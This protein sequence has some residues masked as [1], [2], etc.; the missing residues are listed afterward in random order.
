MTHY[1]NDYFDFEGDCANP[2]ATRW[3]GGS[4]VLAHGKIHRSVALGTAAIWAAI[5]VAASCL[6]YGYL[7]DAL[8]VALMLGSLVLAWAYSAPP[9]RLHSRGLGELTATVIVA[10]LVPAI[11]YALQTGAL[12]L[13]LLLGITPLLLVQYAMLLVV[14]APDA[15]ADRRCGKG[16]LLVRLGATRARHF[17]FGLLALAYLVLPFLATAGLPKAVVLA[18]AC[19]AP[20][21]A[22][23]LWRLHHGAL[24]SPPMWSA[25]TESSVALVF[26]C[27]LAATLGF[28][29]GS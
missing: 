29:L 27:A 22:L 5:A 15:D 21:A 6:T 2:N 19:T 13:D 1:A 28:A 12:S 7:R 18:T 25:L 11:G 17:L 9:L 8:V 14:S 10:G 3:S 4:G 24:E 20:L 23:N 26:L 16:T